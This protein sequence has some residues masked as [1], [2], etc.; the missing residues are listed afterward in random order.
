M[1]VKRLKNSLVALAFVLATGA[2]FGSGTI[3]MQE[4]YRSVR[5]MSGGSCISITP[6]PAP[7]GCT[8]TNSGAYCIIVDYGG[9]GGALF[10]IYADT[11]CTSPLKRP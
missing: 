2:A 10:K 5:S 9:G 4:Q 11:S 3:A 1:N 8:V 6:I 7:S